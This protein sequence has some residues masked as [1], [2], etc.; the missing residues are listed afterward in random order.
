MNSAETV[1]NYAISDAADISH[2]MSVAGNVFTCSVVITAMLPIMVGLISWSL[3]F[4]TLQHKRCKVAKML[5]Q[6]QMLTMFITSM[7]GSLGLLT[8]MSYISSMWFYRSETEVC[9]YTWSAIV[10]F[11]W[12]LFNAFH[13][14]M[15]VSSVRKVRDATECT[16]TTD[17]VQAIRSETVTPG[18]SDNV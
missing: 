1:E 8:V 16:S 14:L 3:L 7:I 18:M 17:I 13:L 5:L 6:A 2:C 10:L 15:F 11:G 12:T 4:R 9:D